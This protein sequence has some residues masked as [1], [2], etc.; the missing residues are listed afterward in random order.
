M[1]KVVVFDIGNVVIKYSLQRTLESWS[2]VSGIPVE[3]ILSKLHFDDDIF[4]RFE[5]GEISPTRFKKYISEKIG[6][7]FSDIEFEQGF[8]AMFIGIMPEIENVMLSLKPAYRIAALSNT[9]EIHEKFFLKKYNRVLSYFDKLF[10]SHKI[11]SRKPEKAAYDT[12]VDYYKVLP[13]EIIFFDDNPENVG[14]AS[15]IGFKSMLVNSIDDIKRGL[16]SVGIPV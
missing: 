4:H 13:T 11:R 8:D 15:S 16:Q 3:V 9:N 10:L 12:V 1:P 2:R 14:K 6:Y 7:E 5:R